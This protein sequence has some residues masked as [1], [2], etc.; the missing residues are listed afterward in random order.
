MSTTFI[1]AYKRA[2]PSTQQT[3]ISPR[4]LKP[5]L[6]M[7]TK[8]HLCR[9]ETRSLLEH[10]WRTVQQSCLEL[11]NTTRR[12]TKYRTCGALL[13]PS[14]RGPVNTRLATGVTKRRLAANPIPAA[15][16]IISANTLS[17]SSAA[18]RKMAVN[19]ALRTS[20]P[21]SI[22]GAAPKDLV[23][24]RKPAQ[25]YQTAPEA[26]ALR[27][28]QPAR[29]RKTAPRPDAGVHPEASRHDA[30][31]RSGQAARYSRR[32]LQERASSVN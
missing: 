28:P 9:L 25:D 16:K 22:H 12:R 8:S 7:S 17:S 21:A 27:R 24:A 31:A 32:R 11:G 20:F 3:S 2:C 26:A 6:K 23:E 13:T 1:N 4:R 18:A 15:H 29:E 30:R 5:T 10:F 19:A 14:R